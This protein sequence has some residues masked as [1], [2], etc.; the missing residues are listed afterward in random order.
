M[1]SGI[2]SHKEI[3][4]GSMYMDK[5]WKHEALSS[6]PHN[7]HK[8]MGSSI[9]PVIPLLCSRRWENPQKFMHQLAH[10]PLGQHFL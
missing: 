3:A 2:G 8:D 9:V 4:H 10:I 5:V 7:P 6:N 1:L